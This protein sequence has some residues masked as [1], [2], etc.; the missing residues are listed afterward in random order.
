MRP[1]L[2][3][4]LG[5]VCADGR[6]RSTSPPGPAEKGLWGLPKALTLLPEE[7]GSEPSFNSEA[8]RLRTLVGEESWLG[9]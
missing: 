6:P 8:R 4:G 3:K 2:G 7:P 9:G 1:F 5:R